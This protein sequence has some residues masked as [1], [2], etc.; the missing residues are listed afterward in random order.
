MA[1]RCAAY[2]LDKAL[3][4]PTVLG[5]RFKAMTGV[6]TLY[7]MRHSWKDIAVYAGVDFELRERLLG[8]RMRGVAAVYGSGSYLKLG[9]DALLL[10]RGTIGLAK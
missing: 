8:H 3:A 4:Q 9:L 5:T 1:L 6:Y 2:G 10:V 7:Q